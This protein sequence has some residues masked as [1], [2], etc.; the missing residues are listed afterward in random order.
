MKKSTTPRRK[1][2]K[3]VGILGISFGL[4][5]HVNSVFGKNFPKGK[6][7]G[8]IG[9]DTSHSIEFTKAFN[10]P[11]A[12]PEFA[13]Y[14]VVFAYPK[15]SNDIESSA[16]RIPGYTEEIKKYGVKIAE[17]INQLLDNVDVVLLETNDGRLHLQQAL[18]VFKAGK[19]VF[20]DKPIAASLQDAVAIYEAAKKFHVPMFSSSSLRFFPEAVEIAS[21]KYGKVLGADVYSPA[22]LEKTH[23]DL[24]WYGIHGVEMLYTIMGTGCKDVIRVATPD[25]DVVV[26]TWNDQRIGTFRGLRAGKQDYGINVYAE[27]EVV[28]L[29][30][31]PGYNP[32]LVQIIKFFETGE[33]PVDSKD[34]LE[35]YAFME[36][37]D[38][39][40]RKGG[41]SISM[42]SILQKAKQ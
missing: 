21:S 25:T 20:I 35:I 32:L 14:K 38:E 23:P 1:F 37:A 6:R 17:S 2:I 15:G 12:G 28:T 3:D 24:F 4:M 40:K 29:N 11:G 10:D 16:K 30:K 34:T 19:P 22:H 7:I 41:I 26:G 13:G 36:A 42:E 9:L 18:Q 27:N 8:I 5:E 39:S 33:P 31:F